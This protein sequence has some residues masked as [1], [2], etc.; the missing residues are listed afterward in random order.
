M[1]KTTYLK[2]GSTTTVIES[3]FQ[4]DVLPIGVYNVGH[5]ISR[6]FFLTDREPLDLPKKIYG[7][8]N[9]PHRVLS[10]FNKLGKGMGVLLSGPK[11]TGK[12]VEAKQICAYSNMPVILVTEGYNDGAFAQFIENIKTPSVF[13][14]D[15]F[16][17]IYAEE[18]SRNFFLSIMDGV[19][20]SR[21][22]F[23]LT[24]N[25]SDIGEYFDSRPGRVRYHKHYDFL[26][27][28]II[29]E[30]INDCLLDK[31]KEEIIKK[32]L[33]PLPQL[34]M[35]SLVCILDECNM[36]GETPK[37]FASFFNVVSEKPTHYNIKLKTKTIVPN[38]KYKESGEYNPYIFSNIQEHFRF[39]SE[40]EMGYEVLD[41]VRNNCII[42]DVEYEH[43]YAAPFSNYNI[44]DD[45]SLS[46]VQ[47]YVD[48]YK[49]LSNEKRNF[50][51]TSNVISNF[52]QN[53]KGFV[54]VHKDGSI[55]TGTPVKTIRG[56]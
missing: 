13:F 30:I 34:S 49:G 22:L 38:E 56:F 23:V 47:I 6:G 9:F 10:A 44:D 17:K 54:A 18:C 32:Q 26:S 24:S 4:G 36:F 5:D 3:D 43:N 12:T 52:E 31:S 42:A 19:A 7:E 2:K 45:F 50:H 20:K 41:F 37:E 35:D 29:E 48:L 51:W 40:D 33:S 55:M 25:S 8:T 46:G 1:S 16:E 15:E 11:G 14:I 21:H 28:E 27:E 53:R 39:G